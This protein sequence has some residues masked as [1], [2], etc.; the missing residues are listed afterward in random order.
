MTRSVGGGGGAGGVVGG[1]A[2]A[3]G[4]AVGGFKKGAAGKVSYSAM[5]QL[6]QKY[7]F[8]LKNVLNVLREHFPN[9]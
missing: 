9:N 4:G 3:A 7:F 2:G 5:L 1:K 6:I 8:K